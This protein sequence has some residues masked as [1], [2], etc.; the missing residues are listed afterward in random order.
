M[1]NIIDPLRVS[2]HSKTFKLSRNM[3]FYGIVLSVFQFLSKW[4][5]K[6]SQMDWY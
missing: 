6:S 2:W 5:K 1:A 3:Y 4:K